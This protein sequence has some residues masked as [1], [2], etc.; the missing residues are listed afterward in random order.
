VQASY[1][2][3]SAGQAGLEQIAVLEWLMRKYPAQAEKLGKR[4]PEK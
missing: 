1:W 4:P 2:R 3:K